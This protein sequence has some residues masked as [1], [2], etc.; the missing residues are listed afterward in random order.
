M[1]PGWRP[2]AGFAEGI[3]AVR[4]ERERESGGGCGGGGDDS[5]PPAGM[6]YSPNE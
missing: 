2:S 3:F 1:L 5:T 4:S 6:Q